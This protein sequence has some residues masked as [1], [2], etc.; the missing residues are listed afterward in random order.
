[1]VGNKKGENRPNSS[2]IHQYIKGGRKYI[3][4]LNYHLF[5]NMLRGRKYQEH[6]QGY[7]GKSPRGG[8]GVFSTYFRYDKQKNKPHP[9]GAFRKFLE[10][11]NLTENQI[12]TKVLFQHS[13]PAKVT[14]VY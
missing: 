8:G 4:N 11:E 5:D 10:R 14:K 6:I 2:G 13:G 3:Q 12:R 1:M 9:P 7:L